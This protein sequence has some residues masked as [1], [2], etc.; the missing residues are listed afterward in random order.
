MRRL[1]AGLLLGAFLTLIGVQA[2][3][4][5][6]SAAA[7]VDSC[8]VCTLG[9]QA[10]RQ[11]PAAVPVVAPV[12]VWTVFVAAVPSFTGAAPVVIADARAPPA[13]S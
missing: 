13:V 5:H 11:A 6:D 12:A 10:Q 4:V 3:H 1:C 2:A 9:H 7:P 8:A